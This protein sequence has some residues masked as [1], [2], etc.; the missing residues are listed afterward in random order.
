MCSCNMI[1]FFLWMKHQKA[2]GHRCQHAIML[3]NMSWRQEIAS[4]QLPSS[5][6]KLLGASPRERLLPCWQWM[7]TRDRSSKGLWLKPQDIKERAALPG[8]RQRA[9]FQ[10]A[11]QSFTSLLQWGF[12]LLLTLKI[13]ALG[14]W[15]TRL[16]LGLTP[17]A[18]LVLRFSNL[19]QDYP[20]G[21]PKPSSGRQQ[22]V[23]LLNLGNHVSQCLI[24]NLFLCT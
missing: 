17:L 2:Q 23:A 8:Q 3:A 24:I 22:M 14:S 11:D 12:H 7:A 13:G 15:V 4:L 9:A 21:F 18:T 20:T 6:M 16:R 5:F 1:T 19:D 10:S